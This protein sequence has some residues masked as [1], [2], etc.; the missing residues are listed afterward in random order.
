MIPIIEY[1]ENDSRHEDGGTEFIIKVGGII[2]LLIF[3]IGAL[4][5]NI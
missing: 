1:N 5:F 4:I 2:I 3:T